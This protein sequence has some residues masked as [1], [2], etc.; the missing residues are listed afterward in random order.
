MATASVKE[1][2]KITSWCTRCRDMRDHEVETVEKGRPKRV[3][4]KI[5]KGSHL[6]R[7][8]P[9]KSRTRSAMAT[10]ASAAATPSWEDLMAVADLDK[11]RTYAMA[12]SYSAG[13][14][15]S[16]KVFGIGIVVLGVDEQ[17]MKVSF[18]DGTRLLVRNRRR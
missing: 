12:R 1:G 10:H 5:C 15:I 6:Y 17:K 8:Q 11:V 18:Q 4:C 9:P 2:S 7:P 13:D 16:H 3:I 14:V